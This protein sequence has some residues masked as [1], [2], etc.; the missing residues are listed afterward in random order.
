[1]NR[2]PACVLLGVLALGALLAGSARA[3][4]SED[5]K[6][7]AFF[8]AYLEEEFQH[9]TARR[10]AGSAT[11]ASTTV[12][13]TCRRR[14][15]PPTWSAGR[16]SSPTCR[17]R[18]TR[19]SCRR[20]GRI[21]F[22]IL[23]HDLTRS[24]WLAENTH[25]F[26]EDPRAYNAYITDSVYALLTQSTLPK[27]KNVQN[28]VARMALIPKV[29]AVAKADAAQPTEGRRRRRR[30]ARTTAPS[31]STRPASSTWP[32]RP[33][34]PPTSTPPRRRSWTPWRTTRSS[35]KTSCCRGRR[36]TGDSARR[37]SPASWS[38]NWTPA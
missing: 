7:T 31:P 6:L 20:A 10:H 25:P 27:E 18:S 32:A 22:D 8:K 21:D 30:S 12:S 17:R 33:A 34:A 14:P 9:T 37:N 24:I 35:W 2:A 4:E 28:A 1:M 19:K 23:R 5:D 38:W 3:A 16:T 13:T 36:A 11:T 15:A 26:E 29:I